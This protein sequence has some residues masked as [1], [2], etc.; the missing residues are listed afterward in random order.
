MTPKKFRRSKEPSFEQLEFMAKELSKKLGTS[1]KI[2]LGC[3]F[4][5]TGTK[6]TKFEISLI[7]GIKKDVSQFTYETWSATLDQ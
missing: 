5:D 3:W 1:C 2:E 6:D 4:H 7:P